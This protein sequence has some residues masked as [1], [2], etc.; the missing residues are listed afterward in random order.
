MISIDRPGF[1]YSDFGKA[2]NLQEQ[3]SILMPAILKLVG[4]K[5]VTL[6]GHSLGAPVI[7]KLA[8]EGSLSIS[9]LVLIAGSVSPAEE[10]PEKWR[11]FLE[12]SLLSYMLPGAFRPSNT[13][14][15]YFK[16]DVYSLPADF[17]KIHSPVLIFHGDKD[18]FVPPGNAVFA[19]QSLINAPV[20]MIWFEGERHFIPWTRFR[21][22]R[23]ELLAIRQ[24]VN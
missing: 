21:E 8:A 3:V 15:V 13:E 17:P 16:K 24:S 6:V 14:I 18:D 9:Q 23:D 5:K 1:G 19:Q 20:R 22:I 4:H 2:V 11:T 7:L 10:A 12:Y